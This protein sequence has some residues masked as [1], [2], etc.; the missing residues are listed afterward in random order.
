MRNINIR[1]FRA[2]LSRELESL[3]LVITKKGKPVAVIEG[4]TEGASLDNSPEEKINVA[5]T[6]KANSFFNPQSK[7]GK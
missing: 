1:K 3:P 5:N 6:G 7:G 4:L 2:N